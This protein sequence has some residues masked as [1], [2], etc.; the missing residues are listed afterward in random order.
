MANILKNGL[1]IKLNKKTF[2]GDLQKLQAVVIIRIPQLCYRPKEVSLYKAL[3]NSSQF[4]SFNKT[5]TNTLNRTII[6]KQSHHSPP[7]ILIH[8]YLQTY[9][10]LN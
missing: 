2:A 6:K 1:Q 7:S 5:I 8:K 4:Q 10:E 3:Q 9:S